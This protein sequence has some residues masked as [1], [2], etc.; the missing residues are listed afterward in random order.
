[1]ELV[2]SMAINLDYAAKNPEPNPR[3]ASQLKPL[4]ITV[5]ASLPI[6]GLGNTKTWELIKEKKIATV[7]IGRRVLIVYRSLEELL[8]TG[9]GCEPQP[10][11]RGRPR[12]L[13]ARGGS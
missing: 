2:F 5:R 12:K 13:I 11:R 10:R 3:P 1:M 6:S 9:T 4:T 7:R 8:T